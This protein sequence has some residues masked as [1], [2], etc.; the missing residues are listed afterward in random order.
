MKLLE[1]SK[2]C[3]QRLTTSTIAMLT[4][5]VGMSTVT[6]QGAA[7]TSGTRP[8]SPDTSWPSK[9]RL[10]RHTADNCADTRN[11]YDG[12]H[13]DLSRQNLQESMATELAEQNSMPELQTYHQMTNA[14][15]HH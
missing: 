15:V 14:A 8:A 2:H 3:H 13:F 7:I 12:H 9:A 11:T 10:E 4:T 5:Q 1:G 6:L